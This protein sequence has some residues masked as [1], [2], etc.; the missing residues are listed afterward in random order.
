[1]LHVL[2]QLG[3]T[4]EIRA[5]L[6]A[7]LLGD[8]EQ[9]CV[10]FKEMGQ[11][12]QQLRTGESLPVGSVEYVREAMRVAEIVEPANM[13]YP[14]N[15]EPYLHR[16][17]R[18]RNAGHVLGTWFVKPVL[19]KTFTGLVFDTMQK[20][21]TLSEHDR[22]QH[23][24][25]L[26][27]DSADEVWVS[28]PV[29]WVSE[30]RYYLLNG[31][32]VGRVR[33]DPDGADDAKLPDEA[34]CTAAVADLKTEFGADVTCSLD[35]GVLSTGETALVEANDAWALGNYGRTLKPSVYL[36]MLISRW[37]QICPLSIIQEELDGD[38]DPSGRHWSASSQT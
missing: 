15:L 14:R 38:S 8:I 26:A 30:V 29:S 16:D 23:A 21:E 9:T 10:E 36:E 32:I 4:P 18:R 6:Q 7:C 3:S 35:M 22:E 28:E 11:H 1:M 25:F 24:L 27:M 17:V 37:R 31:E 34:V 12:A 19:T 2:R 13:S 33:Y 20:V 5:V